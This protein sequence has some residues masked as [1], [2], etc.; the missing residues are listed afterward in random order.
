[1]SPAEAI[2][3][4][5]S[6]PTVVLDEGACRNVEDSETMAVVIL[7][8]GQ[9]DAIVATLNEAEAKLKAT[10]DLAVK[11]IELIKF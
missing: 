8:V 7:D 4:L 10:K 2:A 5:K 3:I 11:A 6:R 9:R 1:M